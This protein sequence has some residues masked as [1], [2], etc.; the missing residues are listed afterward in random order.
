MTDHQRA[1]AE[2]R[3]VGA[4]AAWTN[5]RI[6]YLETAVRAAAFE[7]D[8]VEMTRLQYYPNPTRCR[9]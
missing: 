2:R 6:S 8:A 7:G 1:L 5:S 9:T 4:W 3:R